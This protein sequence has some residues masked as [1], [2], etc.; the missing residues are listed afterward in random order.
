M[1]SG[2]VPA[3]PIACE[4]GEGDID[5]WGEVQKENITVTYG[6]LSVR[7]FTAIK[8]MQSLI[9]VA[10][11]ETDKPCPISMA[12]KAVELADAIIARLERDAE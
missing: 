2:N 9:P 12:D 6:G 4:I 11:A 10:Y 5:F 1:A 3:F 8:M 7:Q